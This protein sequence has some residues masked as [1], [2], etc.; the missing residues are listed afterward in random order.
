MSRST[1]SA[2]ACSPATGPIPPGGETSGTLRSHMRPGSNSL[3]GTVMVVNGN[4]TPE[5]GDDLALPLRQNDGSGNR[6]ALVWGIL[7]KPEPKFSEGVSPPLD[8]NGGP[9]GRAMSVA[10]V[11]APST[12]SAAASPARTSPWPVAVQASLAL[13]L[14]SS[15]SSSEWLESYA[16]LGFCW[17]TFPASSAPAGGPTSESSSIPWETQGTGWRG[18]YW[19]RGGGE[20]HSGAVASSLSA[21]LE[22]RVPSRFSLS[23]RACQGIL[24]RAEKRGRSLPTPLRRALEGVSS[25]LGGTARTPS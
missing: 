14:A 6:Q 8:R 25:A 19:M 9:S 15:S 20:S 1:P 21:V 24:R 22:P 18:E 17:R 3:S 13:A 4:S 2:T 7:D 5:V 10:S 23:P 16:R 11:P 12:S